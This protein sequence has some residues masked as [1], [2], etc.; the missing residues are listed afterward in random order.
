MVYP[1]STMT[2]CVDLYCLMF[3]C[4]NAKLVGGVISLSG[5]V[6]SLSGGVISLSGG[7]I[8]DLSTC[9]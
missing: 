9:N 6:I 4:K 3:T 8:L 5:G 7:V 1:S 2:T